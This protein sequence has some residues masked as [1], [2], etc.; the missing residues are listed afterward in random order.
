MNGIV[1]RV[2]HAAIS[3]RDVDE[4]TDF[5]MNVLGFKLLRRTRTG[6]AGAS[7]SLAYVTLG[8]FTVEILPARPESLY[9]PVDQ[10]RVGARM[11]A[12][13]VQDMAEAVEYFQSKGVEVSRPPS[14]GNAFTG[15]RGEIKDPNGMS[16]ELLEWQS[17]DSINNDAWQPSNLAVTRTA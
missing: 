15:V 13:R 3:V 4:T 8:D 11:I 1:E 2:D 14:P 5:Y 12:L 6:D 16:I 7:Q 10:Y 9:E 17:D